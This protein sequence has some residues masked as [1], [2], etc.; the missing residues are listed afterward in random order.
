MP[1]TYFEYTLSKC[2]SHLTKNV[3]ARYSSLVKLRNSPEKEWSE[4]TSITK[5]H[6]LMYAVDDLFRFDEITKERDVA[7]DSSVLYGRCESNYYALRRAWRNRDGI[8]YELL[9]DILVELCWLLASAYNSKQKNDR[10]IVLLS[11][12]N[13][14]AE[15][16]KNYLATRYDEAIKE[17]KESIYIAEAI[18]HKKEHTW[19]PSF[20]D[21]Q[22]PQSDCYIREGWTLNDLENAR[23]RYKSD[24]SHHLALY[25][26]LTATAVLAYNYR[27]GFYQ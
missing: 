17:H 5:D 13:Q 3:C 6:E 16:V 2:I 7:G 12:Q 19:I 22:Y 10:Y 21:S 14:I 1:E 11:D 25:Y 4:Y 27:R 9:F 24:C 18:R 23:L 8:D 20:Y 26:G 15:S